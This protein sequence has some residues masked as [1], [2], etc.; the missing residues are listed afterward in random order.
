MSGHP[1]IGLAVGFS[2]EVYDVVSEKNLSE[3]LSEKSHERA[4][5]FTIRRLIAT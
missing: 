3:K 4:N 5:L 1:A 2:K